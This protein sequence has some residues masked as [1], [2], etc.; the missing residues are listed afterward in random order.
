MGAAAAKIFLFVRIGVVR[1]GPLDRSPFQRVG[2]RWRCHHLFGRPSLARAGGPVKETIRNP[3]KVF[4]TGGLGLLLCAGLVLGIIST[5]ESK[6]S[7]FHRLFRHHQ[8]CENAACAEGEGPG[9]GEVGGTWYW[10]RSPE[11]GKRVIAGM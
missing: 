2:R 3:R 6:A 1:K 11:E 8:A 5:R 10:V 9:F 7:P 4:W